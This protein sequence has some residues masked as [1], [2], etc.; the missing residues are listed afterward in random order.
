MRAGQSCYVTGSVFGSLGASRAGR[1]LG[2]S[3]TLL[4]PSFGCFSLSFSASSPCIP[5]PRSAHRPKRHAARAPAPGTAEFAT[6][7]ASARSSRTAAS[8][9]TAP[10]AGCAAAPTTRRG[11]RPSARCTTAIGGRR[12]IRRAAIT[13]APSHSPLPVHSPHTHCCARPSHLRPPLQRPRPP[14][15][16][17]G[18]LAHCPVT[19]GRCSTPPAP[20][21]PPPTPPPPPLPPGLP[22]CNAFIDLVLVLDVSG[23]MGGVIGE[24][25]SFAESIVEQFVLGPNATQWPARVEPA[26]FRAVG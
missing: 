16:D 18:Q 14:H 15:S 2:C 24:L 19:C 3:I 21:A 6:T 8:A 22:A 20:P 4:A 12:M 13:C 23:S 17:Y 11:T 10:T 26:A 5:Q 25:R 1:L 7:A 9:P